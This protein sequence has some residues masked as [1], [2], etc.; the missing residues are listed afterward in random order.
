MLDRKAMIRITK[1]G[2]RNW[3]NWKERDLGQVGEY[4]KRVIV[5][6]MGQARSLS[7]AIRVASPIK[8]TIL[9]AT[10]QITPGRN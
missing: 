6:R 4:R 5:T 8:A 3:G 9:G 1:D 10:A 2:G 7:V